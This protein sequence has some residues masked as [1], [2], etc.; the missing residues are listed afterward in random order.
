MPWTVS[1]LL[2]IPRVNKAA[3]ASPT[4]E[5]ETEIRVLKI[6]QRLYS[7][8]S[9]LSRR[10]QIIYTLQE[11]SSSRV[12]FFSFAFSLRS[13]RH[14][15]PLLHQAGRC[16]YLLVL[17]RARG[18]DQ[19]ECAKAKPDLSDADSLGRR[20][21]HLKYSLPPPP[22]PKSAF[23]YWCMLAADSRI[24]AKRSRVL[25]QRLS[26]WSLPQMEAMNAISRVLILGNFETL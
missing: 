17:Q 4:L 24:V 9:A 21:M 7:G 18:G 19:S 23:W 26:E 8:T 11:G 22:K 1:F 13:R 20:R 15:S 10:V 2:I 16:A 5:E 12:C 3:A 14:R 6:K 25:F